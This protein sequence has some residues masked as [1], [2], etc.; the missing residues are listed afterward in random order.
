[1]A[2]AIGLA[3]ALITLVTFSIQ[4]SSALHQTIKD[5]NSHKRIVREL[6][7]ELEELRGILSSLHQAVLDSKADF[8]ALKTP[9]LRCGN[10]CNEF[11][12]VIRK[13]TENSH[14]PRTSIRDWAKLRYMGG[15]I[16]SFK[17]ALASYK[18]TITIAL[19]DANLYVSHL[20]RGRS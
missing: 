8:T 4:S 2:E 19:C 13:A 3:S 16:T 14:G 7:E 12:M 17:N 20:P 11:E 6:K 15:D 1:M 9:L 18:A 10:A 5:F